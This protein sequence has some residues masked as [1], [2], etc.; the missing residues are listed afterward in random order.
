MTVSVLI[1]CLINLNYASF[2]SCLCLAEVKKQKTNV[3]LHFIL[4]IPV[5]LFNVHMHL[6][7]LVCQVINITIII[8]FCTM[9]TWKGGSFCILFLSLFLFHLIHII[10]NYAYLFYAIS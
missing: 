10:V 8:Q 4:E 3:S 5:V 1:H 6:S 7:S 9:V 2:T